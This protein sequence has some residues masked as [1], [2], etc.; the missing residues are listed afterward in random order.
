MSIEDQQRQ[1]QAAIQ[2]ALQG[3]TAQQTA[4]PYMAAMMEFSTRPASPQMVAQNPE[5][6]KTGVVGASYTS[7]PTGK[8]MF[9]NGVIADPNTRD[10]LFPTGE[11]VPGSMMWLQEVQQKWGANEVKAWR[12]RL[13]SQG[14]EVA[15]SGGMAH[16]LLAALQQ[17]HHNRYLNFGKPLALRP[18]DKRQELKQQIDMFAL[19]EEAKA[20]GEVPFGDSLTDDEADYFADRVIEVASRLMSKRGFSPEQAVAGAELR[21]QKEFTEM[22]SVSEALEHQEELEGSN[23]LRNSIVSVAQLGGIR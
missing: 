22:P 4:D 3:A 13:A 6:L 23:K 8:I 15:E 5:L 10:V 21:V 2:Q 19:K 20:W 1:L 9:Q 12:R 7:S 16:D 14:Y 11:A 17:Y 18:A